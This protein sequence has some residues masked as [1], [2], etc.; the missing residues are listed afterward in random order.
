[1]QEKHLSIEPTDI[2]GPDEEFQMLAET[3]TLLKTFVSGKPVILQKIGKGLPRV[4][5]SSPW[6]RKKSREEAP[7]KAWT[8]AKEKRG[9]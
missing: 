2:H 8:S 1:M 6:K 7:P 3:K 4:V 9:A 5:G